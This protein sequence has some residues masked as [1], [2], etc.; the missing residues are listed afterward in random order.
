MNRMHYFLIALAVVAGANVSSAAVGDTNDLPQW[1]TR[2][3]SLADALNTALQQNAAILEAQKDL[4]ATQGLVVQTRAIA[5]PQV[6]ASGQYEYTQPRA[7]ENYPGATNG[8]SQPYRNWNAGIEV[9]QDIYSGGRLIAAIRAAD[10]TK[11]QSLAIYQTAVSDALLNVRVAYYDVLLAAQQ[12]TVRE[13]SVNLLQ[14]ELEDQ[15][16]RLDAG[17][18]PKF[19]VLQAEVALANERPNL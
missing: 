11:K 16:H 10:V 3:L 15:Q 7:I 17:T 5:L 13:A 8:F 9:V 14:K 12:V 6:T 2:P 18:V 19:N 1:L 4:Q